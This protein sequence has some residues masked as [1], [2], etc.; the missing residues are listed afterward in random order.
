MI[1]EFK[2]NLNVSE[3][4]GFMNEFMQSLDELVRGKSSKAEVQQLIQSLLETQ[5]ENGFWALIPDSNVDSDVVVAYW[6]TPTYVASAILMH[7]YLNGD[8]TERAKIEPILVKGLQASTMRGLSGHGHDNVRGKIEAIEIFKKGGVIKFLG[9]CSHLNH[10]FNGLIFRVV[11]G[12]NNALTTGQTKGDW[13]EECKDAIE[14]ALTGFK[15]DE[16]TLIFVYG[17]LL[18]GRSNHHRYLSTAMFLGEGVIIGYILYDLGSYPGVKRSKKGVVKGEVYKVD[19]QTLAAIDMLEGKGSLY[20]RETV[21]VICGSQQLYKVSTYIYNK[22][23]PKNSSVPFAEQPWGKEPETEYVWYAG[24][25]S[26]LFYERFMSYIEGGTSRF[27]KRTYPGCTDK[28]PPKASLPITIPYTMYFGNRSESWEN[29][30]VSFLNTNSEG[31]ALGRMYLITKEQ[32]NEVGIQ[33]GSSSNW[34]HHVIELGEHNGIKIVTLTNSKKRPS[35]PPADSYLNV[36]T[37]G[38]KE[39]YPT[40]SHFD[41]MQYLVECGTEKNKQ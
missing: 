18:K 7:C 5:D 12:F 4:G 29:G 13:G 15:P 36:L 38:L 30:G 24:F 3:M 25:G 9:Q 33:E 19:A 31:K 34:Y 20:N 6:Y 40:M 21:D 37:M 16:G 41:I 14:K 35:C 32:F 28:T 39:T 8:L 11:E 10:E 17:T 22:S 2:R 23:V 1:T 27:N 26:N